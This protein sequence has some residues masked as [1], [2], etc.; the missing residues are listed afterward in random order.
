MSVFV[1]V[2]RLACEK[3]FHVTSKNCLTVVMVI[4]GYIMHFIANFTSIKIYL[5][6]CSYYI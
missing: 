2:L 4:H 1:E 5:N 3:L 6:H